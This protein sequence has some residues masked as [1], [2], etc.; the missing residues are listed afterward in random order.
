MTAAPFVSILIVNWNTCELVLRCLDALPEATNDSLAFEVIVV[1]NG[2]ADG[3]VA[4]LAA[5]PEIEFIRNRVNTGFAPAVNQAYRRAKGE[6]VLLLNSDVDIEPGALSVLVAFL[7]DHPDAGGVAPLYFDHDGSPQPFHFRLPTFTTTLVNGSTLVRRLLPSSE[8]LL[9]EYRMAG[10][11]FSQPRPVPQPSASCLLLRRAFLQGDRIFDER[12]PIFFNDVQLARE[13]TT[14]QHLL[15]VT[16]EA[17]VIHQAHSS[18]SRLGPAG[19]RQYLASV[20]RM[21]GDTERPA[22]VWLYRIIVFLQH[23]PIWMLR[24]PET[25]APGQL[26]RALA[27]DPGPLPEQPLRDLPSS[28]EN[29][30]A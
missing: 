21:L 18:T 11:D 9:R 5:R 27:G 14:A 30:A 22:K 26:V 13:L 6:F 2:S 1:D 24:R 17:S 25:L 3:S 10:E 8:R 12:Y 29:V 16:P 28:T 19:R 4:A 15:W 23:I 7:I 20:V